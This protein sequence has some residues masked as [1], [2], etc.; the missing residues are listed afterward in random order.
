MDGSIHRS[1]KEKDLL[2]KAW[3]SCVSP[4]RPL[5]SGCCHVRVGGYHG[6]E[7]EAGPILWM[8]GTILTGRSHGAK[9]TDKIVAKQLPTRLQVPQL[10]VNMTEVVDDGHNEPRIDRAVHTAT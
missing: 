2:A 8:D 6:V 4:I 7:D 9:D 1:R 5:L 10:L 3:S